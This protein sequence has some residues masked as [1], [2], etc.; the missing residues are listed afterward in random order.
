MENVPPLRPEVLLQDPA[1]AIVKKAAAVTATK[2]LKIVE[3]TL[4]AQTVR[5]SLWYVQT[6]SNTD[7]AAFVQL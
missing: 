5:M 7:P 3:A 6:M 2:T 1:G 4:P